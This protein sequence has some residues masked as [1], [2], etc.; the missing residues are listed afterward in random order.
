M[1]QERELSQDD[2]SRWKKKEILVKKFI[3]RERTS[4]PSMKESKEREREEN[5][6]KDLICS[7]KNFISLLKNRFS[8]LNPLSHSE[9]QIFPSFLRVMLTFIPLKRISISIDRYRG[10]GEKEG[11]GRGERKSFLDRKTRTISSLTPSNA[12]SRMLLEKRF[13]FESRGL[14]NVTTGSRLFPPLSRSV[15]FRKIGIRKYS[16]P[17][18]CVPARERR[19]LL[20]LVSARLQC[21]INWR[22][23]IVPRLTHFTR[24]NRT[25][26]RFVPPR[27]IFRMRVGYSLTGVVSPFEM[28]ERL[29]EFLYR[30]HSRLLLAAALW[31]TRSTLRGSFVEII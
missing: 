15:D 21:E 8:Q 29:Y 5:R 11:R 18:T 9:S 25:V 24:G 12:I 22:L 27:G 16:T 1:N 3:S 2:H 17:N 4:E 30:V 28:N 7:K 23:F 26:D 31:K 14:H 19:S 10:E 6:R 13:E 20:I